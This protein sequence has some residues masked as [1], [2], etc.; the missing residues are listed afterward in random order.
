M[1][2]QGP[3]CRGQ[4]VRLLLGRQ[5]L[6]Q[7]LRQL[8]GQLMRLLLGQLLRSLRLSA[9]LGCSCGRRPRCRHDT[10]L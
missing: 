9:L 8:L 4:L 3:A 7:L 10:K 1:V 6:G 5:L 2:E